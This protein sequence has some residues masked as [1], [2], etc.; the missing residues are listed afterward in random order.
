[1]FK[2][3]I[4]V[5]LFSILLQGLTGFDSIKANQKNI[6]EITS[7]ESTTNQIELDWGID[8]QNNYSY[9]MIM[10]LFTLEKKALILIKI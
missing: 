9:Q 3:I 10:R 7:I 8:S 6:I 2:K 1:V 5:F 4:L